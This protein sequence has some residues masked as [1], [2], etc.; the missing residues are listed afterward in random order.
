MLPG[1]LLLR[2]CS[3]KPH[4]LP[5]PFSILPAF[6]PHPLSSFSLPLPFLQSALPLQI[7][8][9][10]S[11]PCSLFPSFSQPFHLLYPSSILIFLLFPFHSC[12]SLFLPSYMPILFIWLTPHLVPLLS[13][14]TLPF[15]CERL[16][17]IFYPRCCPVFYLY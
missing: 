6:L 16:H 5:L 1:C 15:L 3:R 10:P 12:H 8:L 17:H 11:F 2:F 4:H 13:Y 14:F 7:N 9:P